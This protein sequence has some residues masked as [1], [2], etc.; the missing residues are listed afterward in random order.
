MTETEMQE[1]VTK[2]S[3]EAIF[4]PWGFISP[5][6]LGVTRGALNID[7]LHALLSAWQKS[8]QVPDDR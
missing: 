1:T 4:S 7:G 5:E 3:F 2:L 6:A 8:G